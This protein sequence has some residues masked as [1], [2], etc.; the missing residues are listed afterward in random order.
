M[1]TLDSYFEKY[2]SSPHFWATSLRF[3]INF[4]KKMGW[5]IFGATFSQTHQSGHPDLKLEFKTPLKLLRARD[6]KEGM[7]ILSEQTKHGRNSVILFFWSQRPLVPL[8]L[9]SPPFFRLFFSG[10]PPC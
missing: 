7:V 1:V 3:C 4:D 8:L 2:K 9:L 5:A 10:L 6:A